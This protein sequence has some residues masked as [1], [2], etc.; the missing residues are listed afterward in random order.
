M[1]QNRG[2]LGPGRCDIGLE[3]ITEYEEWHINPNPQDKHQLHIARLEGVPKRTYQLQAMALSLS[4]L[5][6]CD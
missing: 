5:N 3:T 6:S 2:I 4:Y 1:N